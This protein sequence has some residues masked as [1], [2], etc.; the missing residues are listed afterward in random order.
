MSTA[1]PLPAD[2]ASA[3]PQPH[4][5]HPVAAPYVPHIDGLRAIAVLAVIVYHL[6]KTWLPGGFAGVDVFF[7]ISGFVVSASVSRWSGGLGGFLSYFYARRIQRIAPALIACLLVTGL[8]CMLFVPAAWL[9]TAVETTGL[10]AFFGISNLF[11]AHHTESYFSTL[12]EYNPYTHTWSLGVE[13]QFYLLFPLLFFVWTRGGRRRDV[14]I[15]VFALASV[16]SLLHARYLATAN[17]SAGFYLTTT[18]F[19]ELAAGVLLFQCLHRTSVMAPVSAIARYATTLGAWLSLALLVAGLVVSQP[20]RFAFPGALLPVAATLG[21]LGCLHVA[22][23]GS[24]LR[25]ALASVPMVYVGKRSYSLYLWHWPIFVLLRW[26]LGLETPNQLIAAVVA[27]FVAAEFSYRLIERPFRYAAWL[28]RWPRPGIIAAGLAV[29]VSAWWLSDRV[30]GLRPRYSLSTVSRHAHDWYTGYTWAVEDKPGCVLD[31]KDDSANPAPV[32]V[33]TRRGCPE[34]PASERTIFAIGDSHTISY[35]AMLSEYVVRTG[36][37][38]LLYPNLGCTFASLQPQRETGHCPAQGKTA[39][40]DVLARARPGDVLFLAALRLTRLSTAVGPEN[41]QAA[42][43]TMIG[44]DYLRGRRDAEQA[45]VALLEPVAARGVQIV[46]EA[47][48]PLLKVSPFRCADFF[49]AGNPVCRGGMAESRE[50]LERYRQPVL[51]SYARIVARLPSVQ[52]W[53]PFPLLCEPTICPALR[54]GRPLFF[55]GDH[56]SAYGNHLL[57]PHFEAAIR[58]QPASAAAAALAPG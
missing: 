38:V 11:L 30:T 6:H 43:Q 14:C 22:G 54:D 52:V 20:A 35:S 45:L 16:A 48:K 17:P 36:S 27:T 49:N 51:D 56:L 8:L 23:T 44:P 2:A 28:R 12:S 15:G 47:P 42:W 21:L 50:M 26:T 37:T 29:I 58:S 7:V 41:E 5:G 18:R 19:W 32:W 40:D 3:R 57:Y 25:R 24:V 33:L 34:Q 4:G 46:F 9:S 10:R 31:L 55:D 1:L 13:E 53:D 39:I